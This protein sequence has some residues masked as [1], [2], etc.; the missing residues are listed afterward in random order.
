M[1]TEH[2]HEE[3]AFTPESDLGK[4][5]STLDDSDPRKTRII[6]YY[7]T[8]KDYQGGLSKALKML[9][10]FDRHKDKAYNVVKTTRAGFTTNCIIASL[11]QNKR[12][13][14]VAPT[15]KILYDTVMNAYDLYVKITGDFKKLVRP[16]PNNV[17]GCSCVVNK[18]AD[19]P[20][21]TILP[22]VSSEDCSKCT[23][24]QYKLAMPKFPVMST[25]NKCIVSTML[26]EQET[27]QENYKI[28]VV[29]VTYDKLRTIKSGPKGNLF[30]QLIDN[31][32]VVVFDEIGDYLSSAFKG[33]EFFREEIDDYSTKSHTS[34]NLL[35]D[36]SSKISLIKTPYYKKEMQELF[37]EY[38]SPFIK[39][40]L[41]PSESMT[42]PK[43]E[44]NPLTTL[45]IDTDI[46]FK[47]PIKRKM[48]IAKQEALR[49]K[50]KIYSEIF[51]DMLIAGEDSSLILTLIDLLNLMSKK[52]LLIYEM[53]TMKYL[54][55]KTKV[56]TI[57]IS[58]S[59][60]SLMHYL[61][62]WT[63]DD[64][65]TIFSDATMPTYNFRQYTAKKIKNIYYGDPAKTNSK[66]LV[67][68]DTQQ[69]KFSKGAWLNSVTFRDSLLQRLLDT[70][71]QEAYGNQVIWTPSKDIYNDLKSRLANLGI[72]TCT[73]E[74]P[75]NSQ[76]MLTY[77]GSNFTRG[78]SSSRRFQ[79]LLGKANK[80]LT[81]Y[82][83]IAFV[84]RADWDVIANEDLV[85]LSNKVG[86]TKNELLNEINKWSEEIQLNGYT[87]MKNEVPPNLEDYF[88]LLSRAILKEKIYMDSWQAASRAKDPKG[89]IK[90]VV[91]CLGWS[92]DEVQ[93]LIKWGSNDSVSYS[94]ISEKRLLKTQNNSIPLPYV[95]SGD[96]QKHCKDWLQNKDLPPQYLGFS[97]S[98]LSGIEEITQEKNYATLKDIWLNYCNNN[99]EFH[100]NSDTEN[101]GYLI[102]Y[103]R[104]L[105]MGQCPPSIMIRD[106]GDSDF[107]FT[108]DDQHIPPL[109]FYLTD[110]EFQALSTILRTIYLH[111][112]STLGYRDIRHNISEK[113][114]PTPLLKEMWELIKEHNIFKGSTWSLTKNKIIK[115]TSS[116][117]Q[118]NEIQST[119]NSKYPNPTPLKNLLD[120]IVDW[121]YEPH[122]SYE[123]TIQYITNVLHSFYHNPDGLYKMLSKFINSY[124]WKIF[125]NFGILL[126]VQITPTE[127][128]ISRRS[129]VY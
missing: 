115:T 46:P 14:L 95:Y 63:N 8:N 86:L 4:I 109:S 32:D 38:L 25:P 112:S 20:D 90:S 122:D 45:M 89:E 117:L 81:A 102:G 88:K 69:T 72:E 33:F 66:L 62:Y 54:I 93:E 106:I 91:Y 17:D 104:L 103:I 68:H 74:E 35:L 2:H 44:I 82:R 110:N 50:Q 99:V 58:E 127:I 53:E 60:D 22:F 11:I 49:R 120:F 64:K 6:N 76:I 55:R 128:Y 119:L 73:P 39:H 83:H 40:L 36:L 34:Q 27:Y 67:Y 29:T 79:I 94:P 7:Y 107:E 47:H 19:H 65:I 24:S 1:E 42:L 78:V 129:I 121:Y 98:L 23:T 113:K 30:S 56:R 75:V 96:T 12:I 85:F 51:E 101:N 126:D 105:K 116:N 80:P 31:C 108:Y 10:Y 124:D 100:H 59:K 125:E 111:K 92:L 52:Q 28:D 87:F 57:N 71:N 9:E 37:N 70:I 15:N 77:Y 97:K 61:N 48:R 84:R 16:I 3:P 26:S 13:L 123:L 118:Q 5:Y 41:I 21:L 43:V 18:L 114:I